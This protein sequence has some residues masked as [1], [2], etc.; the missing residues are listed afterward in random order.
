M[1]GSVEIP[2]CMCMHMHTRVCTQTHKPHTHLETLELK[3]SDGVVK[4]EE[5][6]FRS[7]PTGQLARGKEENTDPKGVKNQCNTILRDR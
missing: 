2:G 6:L 5:Q 3:E 1:S 4:Y 7:Q